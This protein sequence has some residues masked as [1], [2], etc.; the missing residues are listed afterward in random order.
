M[1]KQ[2]GWP[3]TGFGGRLRALRT[4]AGLTHAQLAERAGCNPFMISKLERGLHE[5]AWPLVLALAQALGATCLEFVAGGR[6]EGAADTN[7]GQPARGPGRPRKA[8]PDTKS[9]QNESK[10]KG[11]SRK[12][13]EDMQ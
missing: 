13:K 2:G 3:T 11:K 4:A 12:R 5:P 10:V 7:S 6:G 9:V 8:K 1:T